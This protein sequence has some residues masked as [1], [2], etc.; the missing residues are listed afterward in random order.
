M[1]SVRSK[2]L[3]LLLLGLLA[4]TGCQSSV[5]SP[6]DQSAGNTA[7]SAA[8]PAPSQT[9]ATP[10]DA[11][12]DSHLPSSPDSTTDGR[13]QGSSAASL[14]TPT[15]MRLASASSG[16]IGGDGWIARTD[17]GGRSW[18]TQWSGQEAIS[19]IFALNGKQAWAETESANLLRTTDG[20]QHWSVAGKAPNSG[21]LHFVSADRAFAANAATAD[22]GK[23]WDALPVPQNIV[24]DAYFHD[25]KNGWA[26][27]QNNGMGIVQRTQDGGKTWKTVM[28]RKLAAPL[29]GALIRSVGPDD[30]WVEWV[31]DSGMSQTSYSLFHT[32]DGGKSWQTVVANSTAGGGPAP[33]FP[34][35]YNGGPKNQGSKPGPLYVVDRKTAYMGGDCPACDKPNTVGKTTDGGK[36]WVNEPAAYP[37]YAGAILGMADAKNGWWVCTDNEKA[38][39]MYTTSDGGEHWK[40]TH[41][42]PA[43]GKSS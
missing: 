26:V 11:G 20:G 35:E 5:P 32:S 39:V 3:A 43:P 33:G 34:L 22:G 27:I 15:A 8:D 37:G 29:N 7:P 38:S 23:S 2:T 12:K 40:K 14:G 21:F 36:T 30:A 24:G 19:Q 17:D 25:E 42:F 13:N 1:F 18:Q 6:A 9:P 10:S 31:G 41:E 28:G 16:W 4:A